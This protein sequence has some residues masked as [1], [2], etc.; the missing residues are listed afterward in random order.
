MI[1]SYSGLQINSDINWQPE[2]RGSQVYLRPL[3]AEDFDILFQAASD[4]LIW[5][6]HPDSERYKIERFKI[7]FDS[8]LRS[9]SAFVIV[10]NATGELIGSSR[11]NHYSKEQNSVEIGYT[12]LI[13]KYWGGQYN[14]EL[15]SL[16]L[17]Y[18]FQFVNTVYFIIG[19]NNHRSRKAIEKIGGDLIIDTSK[20]LLDGDMSQSV[21][22]KIM[23]PIVLRELSDQDEKSFLDWVKHWGSEELSWATFVWKPGMSH[24]DHLQKL[25]D[26]KDKNKIPSLLVPD[27]ML[28]AFLGNKI[29][30]RLSIRH[31][32]NS[33]LLERGGNLGYCV[34][35]K[36][37]KK[38]YAT[39]IVKQGLLVCQQLKLN[40]VLI[41]CADTNVASWKI[42]EKFG[43]TMENK[44]FDEG[45]N[46][47][48]R[49][50]WVII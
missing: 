2:L 3:K 1:N 36:H 22:Y 27:S 48:V 12:F 7:Y 9:Q 11:Y 33:F 45:D 25:K 37:R 32:L 31:E 42:I 8:A 28:Y 13:R 15:K 47:F 46:E 50:Y 19:K 16:M 18:A 23:K 43:G 17:N 41:T 35:P 6:Q 40:K 34:S 49:R 39:E 24:A 10:D 38:G 29:V 44:I 20:V 5:Q 21:A 4:P 26:R 14:Q 30:G